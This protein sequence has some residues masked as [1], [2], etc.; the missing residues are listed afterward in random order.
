MLSQC[1]ASHGL[2]DAE[3]AAALAARGWTAAEWDRAPNYGLLL[4]IVLADGVVEASEI[5]VVAS[6]E[7]QHGV[8]ERERR[9]ALGGL[10]WTVDKFLERAPPPEAPAA[11]AGANGGVRSAA[12]LWQS[13]SRQPASSRSAAASSSRS[14]RRVEALRARRA[15]LPR[16][17]A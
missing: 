1:Q 11:A 10:G 5:A 6:Y 8:T 3:R 16:E 13:S 12:A 15:P 9:R 7:A 14:R 4:R 2:G 17:S